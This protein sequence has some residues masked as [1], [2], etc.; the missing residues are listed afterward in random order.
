MA[1]FLKRFRKII[2]NAAILA[3][4]LLIVAIRHTNQGKP[5]KQVNLA[6]RR[7]VCFSTLDQE[8]INRLNGWN[9]NECQ[10]LEYRVSDA[11]QCFDL[12]SLNETSASTIHRRQINIAFL[13]DS[14]MRQQFYSLLR[15][16]HS[17]HP[18]V[19]PFLSTEYLHFYH[20]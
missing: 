2:L 6:T 17:C 18:N 12:M 4:L 13:G 11:A 8:N 9:F 19:F 1:G 14:R 7:S 5:V 20:S 15:V 3:E 10:L 16:F